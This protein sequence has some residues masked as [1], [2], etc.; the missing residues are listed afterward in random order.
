MHKKQGPSME[1]V[2]RGDEWELPR[3]GNGE[4]GSRGKNSSRRREKAE[5]KQLVL[6]WQLKAVG[7]VPW[8]LVYLQKPVLD[9]LKEV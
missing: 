9:S 5:M 1:T 6:F 7:S 8:A 3:Q 4:G 2:S